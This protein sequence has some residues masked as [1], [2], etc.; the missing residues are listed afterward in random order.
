MS[1]AGLVPAFGPTPCTC[2]LVGE[3]PG[4][5]EA[6]A[7]IPFVGKAGSVL[8]SYL[9]AAGITRSAIRVTNLYPFWP[10]PGNPD[11]TAEQIE[12]EEW[13]LIREVESTGPRVVAAIGRLASR[14]F[15]GDV[16]M[17][18]AHGIPL[19][20]TRFPNITVVACYHPAAGFYDPAKIGRAHV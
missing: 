12:A 20:S 19:P 5:K 1:E 16:D 10:G 6:I 11:P 14:W 17:E 3:A 7:K 15:L 18:T 8:T 4:E 13:R 9:L 2:L